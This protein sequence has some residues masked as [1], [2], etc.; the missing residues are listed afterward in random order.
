MSTQEQEVIAELARGL[1][2]TQD[3]FIE[4]LSAIDRRNVDWRRFYE[5]S[6][7]AVAII[8]ALRR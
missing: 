1:R 5:L 3:A 4:L 8:E 7:E 2:E 6:P